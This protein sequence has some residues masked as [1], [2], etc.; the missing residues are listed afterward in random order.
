MSLTADLKWKKKVS[1]L[2]DQ[3]IDIIQSEAHRGKKYN[4]LTKPQWSVG[5][6]KSSNIYVIWVPE[7]KNKIRKKYLKNNAPNISKYNKTNIID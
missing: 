5:Y 7:A 6:Y 4:R 3:L 2:G 1:H